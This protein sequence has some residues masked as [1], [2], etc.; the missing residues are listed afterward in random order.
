[1]ATGV[2][3]NANMAAK[4]KVNRYE[5]ITTSLNISPSK[6]PENPIV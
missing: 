3:I 1:M 6:D 4:I 5:N 2:N